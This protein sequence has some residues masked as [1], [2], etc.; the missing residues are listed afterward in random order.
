[1]AHRDRVRRGFG[2]FEVGYGFADLR[3]HVVEDVAQRDLLH[4]FFEKFG[5]PGRARTDARGFADHCLIS[6]AT[7]PQKKNGPRGGNRTRSLGL[8]DRHATGNTSRGWMGRGRL[9]ASAFLIASKVHLAHRPRN[10]V[11]REGLEPP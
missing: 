3:C 5:G 6:L 4:T 11:G 9:S 1:M 10:L 2:G 8:E 7:G